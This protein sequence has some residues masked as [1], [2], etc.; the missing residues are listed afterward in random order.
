[1]VK[2][3][4][5]A[6]CEISQ[7]DAK[8]LGIT[9]IPMK[10][11]FGEQE[12]LSGINLTNDEF[13]EK[14]QTSKQLPHTSQINADEYVKTI[15]PM[16]DAGDDVFVMCLSSG[17]SGS[18]NS[19]RIAAEEINSPHLKIMDTETVTIPYFALVYEAVKMINAG[20]DL[21][22]LAAEMEI[23]KQKVKLYAVIDNV[24]YLVKGGRLSSAAGLL[25]S[26]L[27]IKPIISVVDKKIK[28]VGKAV[29]YENA[30]KT[31]CKFIKDV[32]ETKP[33]Y[34]GHSYAPEKAEI[35][36][37]LLV[38]KFNFKF[39]KCCELGPVI[40]THAGPG[41]TGIVYFEK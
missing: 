13:F 31:M 24:K 8:K 37:N 16:I 14:L 3:V 21:E 5:D 33:I 41:C 19:L 22:K 26:V 20:Y 10:V 36:K 18:F 11:N 34:Y 40:G 6:T 39:E 35:L 4:A 23:L 29:G 2:L 1:M 17:L 15:K 25:V 7:E 9:V 30:R 12:Y 32:D 28:M 27:K 38:E